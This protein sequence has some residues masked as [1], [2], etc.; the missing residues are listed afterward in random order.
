MAK[1]SSSKRYKDWEVLEMTK[2]TR[3]SRQLKVRRSPAAQE[4]GSTRYHEDAMT[5]SACMDSL[6][7]K[8]TGDGLLSQQQLVESSS[9]CGDTQ[10]RTLSTI[11]HVSISSYNHIIDR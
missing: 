5:A 7:V 3:K 4:E 1:Q 8:E 2:G 11:H 9:V 10:L 6:S